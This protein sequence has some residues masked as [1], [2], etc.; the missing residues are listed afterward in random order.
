MALETKLSGKIVIPDIVEVYIAAPGW[1][2]GGTDVFKIPYIEKGAG[3]FDLELITTTGPSGE[4]MGYGQGMWK[5]TGKFK[6]PWTHMAMLKNI[7]AL[8][9]GDLTN[10]ALDDLAGTVHVFCK[11]ATGQ[12]FSFF[13][14]TDLQDWVGTPAC[15]TGFTLEG[16]HFHID[17]SSRF[18]E[19][20]L[21]GF[22]TDAQVQYL[23]SQNAAY[24]TAGS[25]LTG[26]VTLTLATIT[27]SRA[28]AYDYYLHTG[29]IG[30]A[31]FGVPDDMSF[32]FTIVGDADN[33]LQYNQHRTL[34]GE[35]QIMGKTPQADLTQ[36]AAI[37][38]LSLTDQSIVGITMG[39]ETI[40][41]ANAR[42]DPKT[43]FMGRN[44]AWMSFEYKGQLPL[45]N[46]N[47]AT[48][49]SPVFTMNPA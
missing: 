7:I 47:L 30:G 48:L 15:S 38:T 11:D 32:D 22:M 45:A 35:V 44:K 25:G 37:S 23:Q 8:A 20:Q 40:T 34:M 19:W 46:C 5:V 26:G 10:T 1:G 6:T 21:N 41:V 9:Q 28:N 14:N 12:F 31:D 4:A 18:I 33:E 43:H 27:A 49:A 2:Q 24:A 17:K 13:R 36:L 3:G 16:T 39:G 42:I 29:T